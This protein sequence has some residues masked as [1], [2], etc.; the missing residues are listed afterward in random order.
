VNTLPDDRDGFSRYA[1]SRRPTD[2]ERLRAEKVQWSDA[3]V[4]QKSEYLV[5]LRVS[6]LATLSE[7]RVSQLIRMLL[8]LGTMDVQSTVDDTDMQEEAARDVLVLVIGDVETQQAG[9]GS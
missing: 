8:D 4:V 3:P 7:H 1:D 6:S 2:T 9:G 5:T